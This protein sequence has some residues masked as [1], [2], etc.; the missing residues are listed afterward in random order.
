MTPQERL[1]LHMLCDIY[2]KLGLDELDPQLIREAVTDDALWV[3]D[4]KHPGL[5]LGCDTPDEVR[6]VLDVLDLYLF[7][8]TSWESLSS[9]EQAQVEAAWPNAAKDVLYKGFDGN[10]ESEYAAIASYLVK[11][12]GRYEGVFDVKQ[13][14]LNSHTRMVPIYERM[15]SAFAPIRNDLGVSDRL[16]SAEQLIEILK[17]Q[18][19]PSNR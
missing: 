8:R 17:E 13:A 16:L 4:W 9:E 14:S 18:V 3:V 10:H 2:E 7:L 1:T 19:H 12:L 6:L 11:D 15:L 5:A